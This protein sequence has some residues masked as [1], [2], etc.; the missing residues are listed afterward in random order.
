MHTRFDGTEFVRESVDPSE[1]AVIIDS[2]SGECF[3]LWH[4]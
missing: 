3:W 1:L 2:R 4:S